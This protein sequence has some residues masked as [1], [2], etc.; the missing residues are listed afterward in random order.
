[1]DVYLQFP[2]TKIALKYRGSLNETSG[3]G[4]C[5]P[6]LCQDGGV[7]RIQC[8]SCVWGCGM[9]EINKVK[10]VVDRTAPCG[11]P[12]EGNLGVDDASLR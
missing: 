2:S 9:S 12:A 11:N 6:G 1:M 8:Q 4:I 7:I 3:Y 5:P 10:R